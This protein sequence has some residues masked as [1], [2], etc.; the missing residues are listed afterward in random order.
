MADAATLLQKAIY[1]ALTSGGFQTLAAAAWP[2]LDRVPG[3]TLPPY[4]KIG[5]AQEIGDNAQGY[6]GSEHHVTIGVW[7]PGPGKPAVK[8]VAAAI[9]ET[10]WPD[11]RPGGS[12]P[13]ALIGHKLLT[14]TFESSQVLDDLDGVSVKAVITGSFSTYPTA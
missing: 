9:R 1:A 11:Q 3:G 4:I 12:A 14:W 2:V 7:G 5:D 8:A 13:F 10:L 6:A